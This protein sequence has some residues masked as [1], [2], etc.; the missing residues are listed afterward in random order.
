[1]KKEEIALSTEE[2]IK[3]SAKKLFTEKGFKATTTR[4][5]A[6]LAETNPALVNYYYRSKEKL[7][8]LIMKEKFFTFFG[9]VLPV[10]N[11]TTTSIEQKIEE[12]SEAYGKMLSVNPD[13][14]GF[15]LDEIRRNPEGFANQLTGIDFIK[16]SV[17]TQQLK[18][19]NPEVHPENLL[20][21]LLSI[22]IFPFIMQPAL[23][24]FAQRNAIELQAIMRERQALIPLWAKAMLD[25]KPH[26]P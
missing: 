13:L 12:I 7:F 9:S 2:K 10:F 3:Q 1:M 26:Q 21:N 6:E 14:P 23:Q 16:N 5:I 17:F 18:E 19:R 15:V 11:D 25:I 20:I 8:S 22:N 24:I 4:D